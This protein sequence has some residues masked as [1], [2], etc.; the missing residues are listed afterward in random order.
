MVSGADPLVMPIW[1]GAMPGPAP[2]VDGAERDL[3]KP[4]ERLIAGRR[5]IRLGHVAKPE[6]HVFLPPADQANGQAVVICPGG[7]FHILAW[8]LEGTEVAEWLN[9]LG[10]AAVVLKYRVP[11]GG[12][13]GEGVPAPGDDS[14][15][16][17]KKS[18]GPMMDA[19]RALSIT[20]AHAKAWRL[21][22][23][24]I[25]LLGFSAGG[26]AAALAAVAVG[27]RAYAAI[28]ETDDVSCAADFALLIYPGGLAEADG[29]LRPFYP[30]SKETP[31]MF[32]AHA[33]DDR[34]T[35]LSSTALFTA[36]KLAE[37]PADLHIFATG[38]H[39]YG[40]RPTEEAITHWPALAEKWLKTLK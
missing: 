1:T 31:P 29:R 19:Q 10:I 35:C 17:P 39:G 18:L 33:S 3:T 20:R 8:D 4:D 21:N 2:M 6:I 15:T 13:G 36:L 7:G 22:P 14:L 16:V 34:V 27:M 40:L 37:V 38:G 30:V 23:E 9:G 5:L 26:E 28:D 12:H 11:T 32:F 24:Q 25:G